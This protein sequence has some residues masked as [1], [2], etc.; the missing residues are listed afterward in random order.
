VAS[1]PLPPAPHAAS[2]RDR[3][4]DLLGTP[5]SC[6][7]R[8]G[9]PS[10]HAYELQDDGTIVLTNTVIVAGKPYVLHETYRYDVD[11][12]RWVTRTQADAYVGSA[13]K[14]SADVWSFDGVETDRGR[15]FPVRMVYTQVDATTFKREFFDRSAGGNTLF[16]SETCRRPD[17]AAS[18]GGGS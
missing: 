1:R 7:T 6:A 18:A 15:K 14:W 3:V 17:A 9:Q 2:I 12:G 5:W 16:L 13:P 8:R 4:Y 11:R 10:T